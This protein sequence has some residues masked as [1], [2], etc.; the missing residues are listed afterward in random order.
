MSSSYNTVPY[1]NG[2]VHC[3]NST[4]MFL[5]VMRKEMDGLSLVALIYIATQ[6]SGYQYSN[7]TV[8]KEVLLSV[9]L[10]SYKYKYN[11]SVQRGLRSQLSSSLCVFAS[12][13]AECD[14]LR[15][16]ST[17]FSDTRHAI[18]SQS[19]RRLALLVRVSAARKTPESYYCGLDR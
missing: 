12:I 9:A 13:I 6:Y 3:G 16:Q 7:C 14:F 15:F 8:S 1:M 17:T 18:S 4:E 10:Y 19:D 11:T 5:Y 2:S